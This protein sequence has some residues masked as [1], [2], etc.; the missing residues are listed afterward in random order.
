MERG[1]KEVVNMTNDKGV[2]ALMKAAARGHA[3]VAELL[4]EEGAGIALPAEWSFQQSHLRKL[5][6]EL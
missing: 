2:S 6:L 1:G 3:A 5:D 4:V